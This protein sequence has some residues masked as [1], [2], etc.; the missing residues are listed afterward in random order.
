MK[1]E[2][3]MK[4]IDNFLSNS[5]FNA[6][7]EL[8]TSQMFPWSY[9]GNITDGDIHSEIGNF[10][11]VKRSKIGKGTKAKHLAYIGD[12][13]VDEKVN[14]GAGTIF[15]NYDGK[16]KNKTSVGTGSFIGSNSSLI[17]PLKIGK[18][19]LIGAGS[20]ITNDIPA[21]KLALSRT[22]Q[23]NIKKK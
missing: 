16:N 13:K 21:N 4:I 7:Q 14:I 3:L 9:M 5:Y 2:I 10:V 11:E 8:V 15:V 20:V 6:L 12:G 17:A 23:R 18:N 22:K 19:S 1:L